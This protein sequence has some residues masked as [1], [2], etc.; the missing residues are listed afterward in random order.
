MD[1]PRHKKSGDTISH[2]EFNALIDA[3]GVHTWMQHGEKQTGMIGTAEF[4][5]SDL[6]I[7]CVATEAIPAYSV[8]SITEHVADSNLPHAKVKR[9]G[10][11]TG[12]S[13][14]TLATNGPFAI[15]INDKFSARIIGDLQ[16]EVVRVDPADIP[17]PG[18]PCG[19]EFEE[20]RVKAKHCFGLICASAVFTRAGVQLVR[21]IR[22]THNTGLIGKVTEEI[23]PAVGDTL[24]KGKIKVHYR[25]GSGDG[26]LPAKEPGNGTNDWVLDVYNANPVGAAVNQIVQIGAKTGIGLCLENPAS[27]G[28]HIIKTKV[29]G[30]D[31]RVGTTVSSAACD[32]FKVVAGT[33]T[34]AG[35]DIT[36]TNITA[37]A[38]AGEVY[39]VASKEI[40][41]DQW[42]VVVEECPVV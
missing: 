42:T 28:T 10:R 4:A 5:K 9:L 3:I 25:N 19:V 36:V 15:A 6:H 35:F 17:L 16:S 7:S 23:T 32:V 30:I 41:S 21:V 34:D 18:H 31:A 24:G 37:G 33:L 22:A 27:G 14:F 13:P 1:L 40:A 29:G 38:V 20:L 11:V 39:G 26:I 12:S 8:F 2:N